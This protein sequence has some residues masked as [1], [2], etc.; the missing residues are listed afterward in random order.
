MTLDKTNLR[1]W[2]GNTGFAEVN[3]NCRSLIRHRDKPYVLPAFK[4]ELDNHKGRMLL[5]DLPIISAGYNSQMGWHI[6]TSY[7]RDGVDVVY[8]FPTERSKKGTYLIQL[9]D[10]TI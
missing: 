1:K 4:G 6:M 5:K 10:A 9:S 7:K 3:V 2:L 8:T